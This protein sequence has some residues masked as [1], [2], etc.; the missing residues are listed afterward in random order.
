M[1]Y[2]T[3]HS[4]RKTAYNVPLA[5]RFLSK[6]SAKSLAAGV[7]SVFENDPLLRTKYDISDYG[8]ISFIDRTGALNVP[9]EPE[10]LTRRE[11]GLRMAALAGETFDLRKDFPIR[12][13]ILRDDNGC[14]VLFVLFHHIAFDMRSIYVFMQ[15]LLSELSPGPG[16]GTKAKR[17]PFSDYCNWQ[18]RYLE[19]PECEASKQFWREYLAGYT[20]TAA[21]ASH[22]LTAPAPADTVRFPVEGCGEL[23]ASAKELSISP[24]ALFLTAH[25]AALREAFG[26][27]DFVTGLVVAGRPPELFRETY[28]SFVNTLPL[29]STTGYG[30]TLRSFS[31]KVKENLKRV[32]P[33][34]M[35]PSMIIAE[36]AS[37]RRFGREQAFDSLFNYRHSGE[38][39]AEGLGQAQAV[40]GLH[41][42]L[43]GFKFES[44]LVPRPDA[45]APLVVSV[46]RVGAD[47]R[48][49]LQYY[50]DAASKAAM[51]AYSES[52]NEHLSAFSS[53][54]DMPLAGVFPVAVA[55]GAAEV[56]AEVSFPVTA[57]P[58]ARRGKYLSKSLRLRTDGGSLREVRSR[59][60]AVSGILGAA[61]CN[62]EVFPLRVSGAAGEGWRLVSAK[63]TGTWKDA[64][65][66][67]KAL[68]GERISSPG[69]GATFEVR[70]CDGPRASD[71]K[72]DLSLFVYERD[73]GVYLCAGFN[74]AKVAP[75]FAANFCANF[76]HLYGQLSSNPDMPLSQLSLVADTEKERLLRISGET[77]KYPAEPLFAL[78]SR[79]AGASPDRLAFQDG[80]RTYTYGEILR[81]AGKVSSMLKAKGVERGE[82]VALMTGHSAEEIIAMLGILGS[83]GCYLP[84]DVKTPRERAEYMAQAAKARFVFLSRKADGAAGHAGLRPLRVGDAESF[85]PDLGAP[86]GASPGDAAYIMFTSGTTATPKGIS[87]PQRAVLRLVLNT[88][89]ISL[90]H[91]DRILLTS[92]PAFD[93]ATFEIWG[94]LL[95]GA[96]MVLTDPDNILNSAL[97]GRTVEQNKISVMWLTAPLFG[98]IAMTSPK[99]FRGL[100]VLLAGGDILPPKAVHAAQKANP[101]LQI[102]NGYGPT[103]NTTFTAC[104]RIPAVKFESIP[105][106]KPVANTRVFILDGAGR[107]LPE[108]AFGELC[109]SGDGLA[110][111]YI[112][113]PELTRKRFIRHPLANGGRLY[114][115]GDVARWNLS[116][117]LEFS[118][119]A[120]GQIK[121]RGFRIELEEITLALLAF[122]GVVRAVAVPV[123][124]GNGEKTICAYIEMKPGASCT[125]TEIRRFLSGRLP[126]YMVPA[127]YTFLAGLPL[128]KNGKID[129]AALPGPNASA[130]AAGLPPARH[131]TKKETALMSIWAKVLGRDTVGLIDNFF[132]LGGHS[133]KAASIAAR[134]NKEFKVSVDVSLL[135][136]NPTVAELAK[137]LTFASSGNKVKNLSMKVA[138]QRVQEPVP[139]SEKPRTGAE[140]AV[141]EIVSA[142]LSRR[143]FGIN[144]DFFQFGGNSLQAVRVSSLIQQRFKVILPVSCIYDNAT[145]R[146][147]SEYVEK[148]PKS[149]VRCTRGGRAVAG[150]KFK[151][152]HSQR[153]LWVTEMLSPGSA[154]Y[155]VPF[156]AVLR[157]SI[158]EK[159]FEKALSALVARQ[160]IL[161][162]YLTSDGENVFQAR[163]KGPGKVLKIIK[164]QRSDAIAEIEADSQKP[165]NLA[166]PP[167]FRFRLF[168]SGPFESLFYFNMHHA[169][170]DGASTVI[171]MREL[172]TLYN[173]FSSGRN[174][175]MGELK[176]SYLD[177]AQFQARMLQT[178]RLD[179]QRVY[180]MDKLS[181]TLP[182]AGFYP[183]DADAPRP[184]VSG[185]RESV[186]LEAELL[187]NIE[188]F[189]LEQRV[190][191][192]VFF[193][194]CLKALIH[195]RTGAGDMVVGTF[196]AGRTDA[197]FENVMGF[198]V[199]T[200]PLRDHVAPGNTFLE[201]LKSVNKTTSE[202][203][204]N[205]DYPFDL[206]IGE[207]NI[208]RVYGHA[209]LSEV[210]LAFQN[211]EDPFTAA[212][213]DGI[214]VEKTD[215]RMSAPKF[216]LMFVVEAG[217]GGGSRLS[218]D[219]S[220]PRFKRETVA[221]LLADYLKIADQALRTPGIVLRDI[222]LSLAPSAGAAEKT[223][224][225]QGMGVLLARGA[226]PGAA[227]C[228]KARTWT[229]DAPG[230]LPPDNNASSGRT[231][232]RICPHEAFELV[233][234]KYPKA[235]AI[236]T[237]R[238][239]I[240]YKDLN[241]KSNRLAR[242]LLGEGLR[243]GQVVAISAERGIPFFAGVLSILKAGCAY[244]PVERSCP[245][246]RLRATLKSS[247]AAAIILGHGRFDNELGGV[248]LLYLSE[249]LYKNYDG[250]DLGLSI[251]PKSMMYVIYTSGSTGVPKGVMISHASVAG[252]LAEL[253][254]AYPLPKDGAYLFKTASSFDVS[255]PEIFMGLISGR[256]VVVMEPGHELEPEQICR[257]ITERRV[258]HVNFVPSAF[259][260]FVDYLA[261]LRCPKMPFLK[262]VFL[263]GEALYPSLV[264]RWL[265][266]RQSN[267]RA[268]N[269]YGPTEFT[270]YATRYPLTLW[271]GR[272]K[273]LI[274]KPFPGVTAL[275]LDK[276][277]RA[278]GPGIPG[279][280][281]LAGDGIA[282]GYLGLEDQTRQKFIPCPGSPGRTMYRTGDLARWTYSGDLEFLGRC[283]NQVKIRGHRIELDEITNVLLAHPGI[284]NAVCTAQ[285]NN[286]RNQY[287]CAYYQSATPIPAPELEAFLSRK[288]PSY[289]LPSYFFHTSRLPLTESN[290]I[291][292]SRL[293]SLTEVTAAA[294]APAQSGRSEVEKRI[295]G[296][297]SRML[298]L[299]SVDSGDSFFKI[300][301]HSLKLVQLSIELKKNFGVDVSLGRLYELHTIALQKQ[302]IEERLKPVADRPGPDTVCSALAG[303][304]KSK[305][306]W[307]KV[308][309]GSEVLDILFTDHPDIP[310]VAAAMSEWNRTSLPHYVLPLSFITPGDPAG[311]FE[312][313]VAI[314]DGRDGFKPQLDRVLRENDAQNE[315][316]RR[317]RV[318][319]EFT[320]PKIISNYIA[321]GRRSAIPVEIDLEDKNPDLI[322][323]IL[324]ELVNAHGVLRSTI[325]PA[326]GGDVFREHEA[327]ELLPALV[328]DLTRHDPRGL[329]GRLDQVKDELCALV[330]GR[331]PHGNILFAFAEIR[332]NL[333]KTRL[334]FALSHLISDQEAGRVIRQFFGSYGT[335]RFIDEQKMSG[336]YSEYVKRITTQTYSNA[337]SLKTTDFYAR[338]KRAS[339]GFYERYARLE[340]LSFSKSYV[341][342]C[343]TDP[344]SKHPIGKALSV[345]VPA[346]A[347]LFALRDVPLR[348]LLNNRSF[349]DMDYYN[350]LGDLHDSMP[351]VLDSGLHESKL[352]EIFESQ[353][354][355][356]LRENI[357]YLE[358]GLGDKELTDSFD[359]PISVNFSEGI[360]YEKIKKLLPG[361]RKVHGIPYP[362]MVFNLGTKLLVFFP[363]GFSEAAAAELSGIL[364]A[365]RT[366]GYRMYQV[367]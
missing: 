41:F 287:I 114:R 341:V 179:Q 252:I 279:E 97:L 263:A 32:L 260:A 147:I 67:L 264:R 123:Q 57:L 104:Y 261:S 159:A 53:K 229:E 12:A 343:R 213:F 189:C 112:N 359:T 88:N 153:R 367:G 110:D 61:Y 307:H 162:T 228:A 267:V 22:T 7:K 109:T 209:P 270:I 363:G 250:K 42:D 317:G 20:P 299:K 8:L 178:G 199:N 183:D 74:G 353:Y 336:K 55:S 35:V 303:R 357:N 29:R 117:Q 82:A 16:Q 71:C 95:N 365:R 90:R 221:R 233:A 258:S 79:I 84:I 335:Q 259:S 77:S 45:T 339:L 276:A 146:R 64:L 225:G 107:M 322:R 5:V 338:L 245:P 68:L 193:Q 132:E 366:T 236:E 348:I 92:S 94:A 58:G 155:N 139:L 131:A 133:L 328:L 318:G 11:L 239:T 262:H 169:V 129:V 198:F 121:V 65:A 93:A 31:L 136:A 351:M 237:A 128:N 277:G 244:L 1:W 27:E 85:V 290:K 6:V 231:S 105:I 37:C 33:H 347:A 70:I 323:K 36:S 313:M 206:I 284:E 19:S 352:Y 154:A 46:D 226:V 203:L 362:V 106:G 271:N 152:S 177:Y 130:P 340:S 342:E 99:A 257:T 142:V 266:L 288:L 219:Y 184:A 86:P 120:D 286:L 275:V 356:K 156:A 329:S 205:Q 333:R 127:F 122:P 52:F 63:Q 218:C 253:R 2:E 4:R 319:L 98:H 51:L 349:G 315:A 144:D 66:S 296:I 96:S 175:G 238:R 168:R 282:L 304:F 216:D 332:I 306:V 72:C 289:M 44:I 211:N 302:F 140:K 278:L 91:S 161:R 314:Q 300:G 298:G 163:A 73:G 59:L 316:L 151:A 269:L 160:G 23:L 143:D 242:H 10:P 111:G 24:A 101:G 115:T 223:S 326:N 69:H 249:E 308:K 17:A 197:R 240:T 309:A 173:S 204:G 148:L 165:F 181:G 215:L 243:P 48:V 295:A 25:L 158:D 180:W 78:F 214:S 301:G 171:F 150:R 311:A 137:A 81:A 327:P 174:G 217:A 220:V 273:M 330:S 297:W 192:F 49:S 113:D 312:K 38:N 108:G 234:G 145:V 293:K 21:T 350:T 47:F 325:A 292:R 149:A 251:D 224:S 345:I 294:Q 126:E 364:K 13:R 334:V 310:G 247:G 83:G 283:D 116:G 141:W 188:R 60:E 190:T 167:L 344:G 102:V 56:L 280:L 15:D 80:T 232:A 281:A 195:Q 241:E 230:R 50:Q 207:L 212:G 265:K 200:L 89:Y 331:D 285:E 255:V 358:L 40:D 125:Q 62:S 134:I 9:C 227:P 43:R 305:F 201:L 337:A 360:T 182:D 166:V 321:N 361:T 39:G 138:P 135:Y 254:K 346:A 3:M 222:V 176:Y 54:R 210:I 18:E 291:D 185:A 75:G 118:G 196:S 87:I 187:K 124:P 235:I 119:R 157:G 202:A 320:A 256:R 354:A 103:E 274:G 324:S 100:R 268:H 191:P 164:C 30:E 172:A 76:A 246:E 272:G 34:Q 14:P 355:Y 248:K 28:G 170:T 208:R 186:T 194:T 26:R